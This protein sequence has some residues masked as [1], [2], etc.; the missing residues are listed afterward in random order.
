MTVH[1]HRHMHTSLF[2][3][4]KSWVMLLFSIFWLV[5]QTVVSGSLWIYDKKQTRVSTPYPLSSHLSVPLVLRHRFFC[6][7]NKQGYMQRDTSCLFDTT[8]EKPSVPDIQYPTFGTCSTAHFNSYHTLPR[9]SGVL[10]ILVF[11]LRYFPYL[12]SVSGHRVPQAL[13]ECIHLNKCT[14]RSLL[15]NTFFT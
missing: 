4:S 3:V 6:L 12:V 9:P 8:V 1:T 10:N 15:T 13:L 7:R 11:K 5:A 2:A 14:T